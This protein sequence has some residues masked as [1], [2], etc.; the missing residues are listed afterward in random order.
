MHVNKTIGFLRS[1]V[2]G[3]KVKTRHA[4]TMS[5]ETAGRSILNAFIRGTRKGGPLAK[6]TKMGHIRTVTVK[7]VGSYQPK[8][9]VV[10][11]VGTKSSTT[12][13]VKTGYATETKVIFQRVPT[14]VHPE[15]WRAIT[16]KAYIK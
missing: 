16:I 12:T 5:E 11:R 2:I 9:T 1:R 4:S 14:G 3:P 8:I 7:G 6:T 13:T 15:G 10:S